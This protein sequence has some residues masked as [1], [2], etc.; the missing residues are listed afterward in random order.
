VAER[1][2]REWLPLI[3][4]AYRVLQLRDDKRLVVEFR[5]SAIYL[6]M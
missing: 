1:Q 5:S 6:D 4:T 3:E 2:L